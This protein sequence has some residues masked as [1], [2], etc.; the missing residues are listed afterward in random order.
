MIIWSDQAV[1]DKGREVW[2]FGLTKLQMT[3]GWSTIIW[4]DQ[5]VDVQGFDVR[6]FGLTKS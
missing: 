3:R 2:L 4:P 1:D 6:S 5:A